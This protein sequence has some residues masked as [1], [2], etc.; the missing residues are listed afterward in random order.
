MKDI[1]AMKYGMRKASEALVIGSPDG[2]KSWDMFM[3]VAGEYTPI[4]RNVG[5]QEA[6]QAMESAISEPL[7]Q[8][9]AIAY[10]AGKN[11]K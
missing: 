2:G 11:G 8:L 7:A 4:A 9:L 3:L 5:N 10:A 1:K 6:A